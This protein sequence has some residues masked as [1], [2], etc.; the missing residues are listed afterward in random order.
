MPLRLTLLYLILVLPHPNYIKYSFLIFW[1]SFSLRVEIQWHRKQT[2][3]ALENCWDIYHKLHYTR[4]CGLK[5]L[6]DYGED[7]Q[8]VYLWW[9]CLLKYDGENMNICLHHK[10]VLGNVFERHAIKC[11]SILKIHGRKT[12]GLKRITLDIVLQIKAKNFNVQ[13]GHMLCR[14]CIT[15]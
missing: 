3:A 10:Q 1:I 2:C 13:P 14:Q 4:T 8:T 7:T 9:A 12:Q 11:C 5:Q 6:V 15:A